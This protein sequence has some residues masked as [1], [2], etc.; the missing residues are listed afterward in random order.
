MNIKML[1]FLDGNFSSIHNFGLIIVYD[2][3]LWGLCGMYNAVPDKAGDVPIP[4]RAGALPRRKCVDSLKTMQN[5]EP[6]CHSKG[7]RMMLGVFKGQKRSL[8]PEWRIE[9]ASHRSWT[10]EQLLLGPPWRQ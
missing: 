5:G 6:L 7:P 4:C 10:P 8:F 1:R 9:K 2:Q 3:T